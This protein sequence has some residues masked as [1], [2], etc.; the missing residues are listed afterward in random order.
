MKGDFSR[1]GP[2]PAE[3]VTG[4]WLQQGRPLLDSDWN[5][6]QF[7]LRRLIAGSTDML[8]GGPAGP[9]GDFGFEISPRWSL[10]LNLPLE[11]RDR[12]LLV[13]RASRSL[14]FRAAGQVIAEI[15]ELETVEI[16][17]DGNVEIDVELF[18]DVEVSDARDR[19]YSLVLGVRVPSGASGTLL[20]RP[21]AVALTL[22][23]DGALHLGLPDA[24]PVVASRLMPS[25]RFVQLMLIHLGR[26]YRLALDGELI[27]QWVGPDSYDEVDG[28][29]LAIAGTPRQDLQQVFLS[30]WIDRLSIWRVPFR[31]ERLYAR[32]SRGGAHGRWL[33][34]DLDFRHSHNGHVPD[35]TRYRNA[36]RIAATGALHPPVQD[37]VIGAGRYVVGGLSLHNP[38]EV[39]YRRQPYLPGVLPPVDQG[40]GQAHL[41]YLDVWERFVTAL[42]DPTLR[43][44]ALGGPDTTG[45]TELIWQCKAI[46]ATSEAVAWRRWW[47]MRHADPGAMAVTL[48]SGT[49]LDE[50]I[51]NDLY[52]VEIH[53][54]GF[55]YRWPLDVE[56]RGAL[57]SVR[58]TDADAGRLLPVEELAPLAPGAPLLLT[59]DAAHW[60]VRVVPGAPGDGFCVDGLPPEV[61]TGQTLRLLPLASF[62]WSRENGRVAFPVDRITAVVAPD[63]TPMARVQLGSP[64]FNGLTVEHGDRVELADPD[65]VLTSRPGGIYTV[66]GFEPGLLQVD[67]AMQVPP[68]GWPLKPGTILRRWSSTI[69]SADTTYPPMVSCEPTLL[70]LG[71]QVEFGEHGHYATGSWWTIPMRN[72]TSAYDPWPMADGTPIAL[73]PSGIR[74]HYA[75]LA[76]LRFADG[77][78]VADLRRGFL[79]LPAVSQATLPVT[80]DNAANWEQLAG[81]LERGGLDRSLEDRGPDAL[82]DEL[83]RRWL[84]HRHPGMRLLQEAG[85]APAGF[86]ATGETVTV[87]CLETA[88]WRTHQRLAPGAG[89]SGPGRAIYA[90]RALIFLEE[91]TGQAWRWTATDNWRALP[92]MPTPRRNFVAVAAGAVVAVLCGRALV[93]DTLLRAIDILRPDGVW[94]T[95]DSD[96]TPA[97]RAAAASLGS[98]VYVTGGVDASGALSNRAQAIELFSGNCSDCAPMAAARADHAMASY[99][100]MVFAFGGEAET[101]LD[102]V[103]CFEPLSG[104][105]QGAAPLPTARSALSAATAG[106]GIVVAGGHDG[107]G[108]SDAAHL[109]RPEHDRW[110]EMSRLPRPRFAAGLAADAAAMRG[111]EAGRL[112]LVAGES[113]RGPLADLAELSVTNT[114]S[115]IA[116]K[117]S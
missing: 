97:V 24:A 26:H 16:T 20:E 11:P 98:T 2:A 40:A 51:G 69:R 32:L 17:D 74:H 65:E 52:R 66:A 31:P 55:A 113:T 47:R 115:L 34:C 62:K 50:A 21:G 44:V 96:C 8:L 42:D 99:G 90:G 28:A 5:D 79:D 12:Q 105:W 61:A 77:L 112:F 85:E 63:G 82:F 41:L 111:G 89:P 46:A 100:D 18:A 117:G 39:D 7:V 35:A 56:A 114:L 70:E 86:R 19:P 101:K 83:V 108:P 94:E 29:V 54:P 103:E 88:H 57:T 107:L 60:C 78:Q 71:I 84:L 64:G 102:T 45:R 92:P 9:L 73:P 25:E 4:I 1:L 53:H 91:S 72:V 95:F 93:G 76:M 10:P 68:Q 22:D 36:G 48:A 49:T 67:L 15:A 38:R 59:A 6:A 104:H 23:E 43:E 106:P 58:V 116:A 37:L 3:P 30:C 81:W 27:A 13:L 110:S 80:A 87:N 109:Y 75:P 14:P 33:V